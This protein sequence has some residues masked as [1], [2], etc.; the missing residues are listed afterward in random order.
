M[1]R[2]DWKRG[3]F[4]PDLEVNEINN[5]LRG[6]QDGYGDFVDYFRFMLE[7]SEMDDVYDEGHGVGRSYNGPIPLPSIQVIH[8]EGP[9]ANTEGGFYYRD[10]ISVTV[11]YA[12][13]RR[14][15][16]PDADVNAADYLK[17][18]LVYDNKVFR[19]TNVAVLGQLQRRD[20]I[21]S[22]EGA[23]VKPDELVND[24]QFAKYS[25]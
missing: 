4:S 24:L 11:S 1:A 3:R 12:A 8:T 25:D 2:L 23:H 20:V 10:G 6:Y 21:V 7:T 17:D 22:F 13:F 19:V 14:A 16:F 5:A 15:G 9:Q 18:R